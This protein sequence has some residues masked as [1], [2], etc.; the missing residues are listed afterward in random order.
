MRS[1][2][3]VARDFK[4]T[5]RSGGLSQFARMNCGYLPRTITDDLATRTNTTIRT[6][7]PHC[8]PTLRRLRSPPFVLVALPASHRRSPLGVRGNPISC[9]SI[10]FD[11]AQ[12][13]PVFLLQFDSAATIRPSGSNC[14]PMHR[15]SQDYT[16]LR[17]GFDITV[18]QFGLAST[19]KTCVYCW[20]LFRSADYLQH[21][22]LSAAPARSGDFT[23]SVLCTASQIRK[24]F[25]WSDPCSLL[26]HPSDACANELALGKSLP[27]TPLKPTWQLLYGHN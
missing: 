15:Q 7:M 21:A 8:P 5:A 25:A 17:P 3:P 18:R 13:K 14:T 12:D 10:L 11:G 20:A 22:P 6:E 26:A 23:S 27:P 9:R 1:V 16:C 2:R 4:G 24:S 19:H